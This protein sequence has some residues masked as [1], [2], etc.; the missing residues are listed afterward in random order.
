MTQDGLFERVEK[1]AQF[2]LD[3]IG[4]KPK[5]GLVLGSGLGSFVD[6]LDNPK[7]I[8]YESIPGFPVSTVAGH[9]GNLVF[10]ELA[11]EPIIIMQGRI[12][13]YE[14]ADLKLATLPARVLCHLGLDVLMLT[15]SAGAVNPSFT[16]GDLMLIE[17][18]INLMGS[19]PLMGE[20]DDRFGPR[21][22]DMSAAYDPELSKHIF[23]AAAS[24]GLELQ[25]GVY[26]A[27][28]GPAYETPAEIRMLST[29][30]A[31]AVGMSTAPEV[32]V[33]NHMGVRCVGI[34]CISNLAAGLSAQKLSHDEVKETAN[35]VSAQFVALLAASI[36]RI[37]S[38]L[39]G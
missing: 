30:G 28:S 22:P 18:H 15:N 8:P 21:F 38:A 1:I 26:C 6:S 31:D 10:A 14:V 17:D 33:A 37:L 27:L 4:T 5:V 36:E 7:V 20:N 13:Y 34:S 16:P 2:I 39:K 32:I 19:N 29:L 3:Q 23:A 9:A 35:S 11:G 24:L 12:H 25:R